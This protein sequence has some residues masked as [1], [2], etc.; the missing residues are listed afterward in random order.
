MSDLLSFAGRIILDGIEI[1]VLATD[2]RTL[3]EGRPIWL[4]WLRSKDF[5]YREVLEASR[6]TVPDA[7]GV[8][9]DWAGFLVYYDSVDCDPDLAS[10]DELKQLAPLRS[11]LQ[12][13]H[14]VE[15][16]SMIEWIDEEEEED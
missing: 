4:C 1:G 11:I 13:P 16:L 6:Y 10:A 14:L 9:K 15:E 12:T 7:Q 3:D 2:Y 5:D 8:L